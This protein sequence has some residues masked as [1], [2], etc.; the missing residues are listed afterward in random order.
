MIRYLKPLQTLHVTSLHSFSRR[1]RC[2]VGFF[3]THIMLSTFSFSILR[4]DLSQT[5]GYCVIPSIIS[6]TSSSCVN[7]NIIFIAGDTSQ[8]LK[9][10]PK[11]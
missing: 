2:E 5:A 10:R 6:K 11:L 9:R 8:R 3:A 1:G 4:F 7:S